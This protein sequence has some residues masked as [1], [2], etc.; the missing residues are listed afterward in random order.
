MMKLVT[1]S[2]CGILSKQQIKLL[3]KCINA[4]WY[5]LNLN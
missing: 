3:K 4:L 5:S 2:G 1:Q